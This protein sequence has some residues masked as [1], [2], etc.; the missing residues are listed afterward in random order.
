MMEKGLVSYKVLFFKCIV[1]EEIDVS[2]PPQP[3]QPQCKFRMHIIW[4]L[5]SF[6]FF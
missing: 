5:L 4:M 1:Y 2:P 3:M 6:S